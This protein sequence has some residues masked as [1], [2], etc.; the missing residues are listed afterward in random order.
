[1]QARE[2]LVELAYSDDAA[3]VSSA[4][5]AL[6]DMAWPAVAAELAHLFPSLK[7]EVHQH[8]CC[9]ALG[10]TQN[11]EAVPILAKVLRSSGF[12]GR[13][14]GKKPE[15][16]AAAAWALG[17]IGTED[18]INALHRSA[19]DRDTNVRAAVHQALQRLQ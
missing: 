1:M 3:L 5:S 11:P 18:A 14:G 10:K 7:S 8:E 13:F 6:G 4:I 2:S 17:Q 19:D 12:L 15:V 16:R 9:V